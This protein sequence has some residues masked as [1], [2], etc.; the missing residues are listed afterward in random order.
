[1]SP[2]EF[3]VR[4]LPQDRLLRVGGDQTLLDAVLAAGI[5]ACHSCQVGCCGSCA[6]RLLSGAVEYPSGRVVASTDAEVPDSIMLCMA[7]ARSDLAIELRFVS[8]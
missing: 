7:R 5:G 6:A 4:V 3:N 8:R 2:A 1:M